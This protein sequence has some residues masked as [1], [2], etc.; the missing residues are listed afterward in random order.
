MAHLQPNRQKILESVLLL[1]GE[2]TSRGANLTQYDIVKSTVGL[3]RGLKGS[4]IS[5]LA[6]N[7]VKDDRP[8]LAS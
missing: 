2:A 4:T 3:N 5:G 1:I 7:P 8:T 6:H